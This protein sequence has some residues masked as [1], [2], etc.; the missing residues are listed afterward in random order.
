MTITIEG[1]ATAP[2]DH[3]ELLRWVRET[4]ELTQPDEVVWCDGSQEEW[5][6]ITDLLVSAGRF[7]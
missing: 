4:A 2:I 7:P 3:A 1:L 6:R 5:R